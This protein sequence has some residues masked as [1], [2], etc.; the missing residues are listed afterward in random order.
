M[1][2]IDAISATT[3]TEYI[4]HSNEV[5]KAEI[6]ETT[7]SGL[8]FSGMLADAIQEQMTRMTAM[9]QTNLSGASSGL[10]PMQ[11]TGYGIEDMI[12]A[13]ASSGEVNDAQSALFMLCMM[14][15]TSS[16]GDFSI[17]MQMMASMMTQIKG[18]AEPLRGAVLSSGYD[19]YILDTIDWNVLRSMPGYYGAGGAIL[20]LEF[21][22]PTSPMIRSDE[23]NRNPDLY[24]SVISQFRV[25]TAERYRPGRNGFTYCNIFMWDVTAAMGAEIPHYTN[26]STGEAMYYPDVQGARGMTAVLIDGWLKEYGEEYGWRKV[27]AEPAQ[28]HANQGRPA[29]TTAG[30]ID[31]VQVI[32]PSRDGGYDPV[33]GVTVAQAGSRVTSYTY[34]SNIYSSHA[35]NNEISYWIHD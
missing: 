20:P 12:L 13:A 2:S 26:P 29:V 35:L 21:W 30:A 22:K 15:Q 18:D 33:R 3:G 24:R 4:E 6:G 11:M 19:P 7:S 28:M 25:E 1:S 9:T 14:M 5:S 27:D 34:I 16:D 31:H 17:I 32:C 23:N 8:D 10:M